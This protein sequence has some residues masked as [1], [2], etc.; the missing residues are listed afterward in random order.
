MTTFEQIDGTIFVRLSNPP[1]NGINYASRA[2]LSEALDVAEAEA[3]I[4]AVVII[5]AGKYFSCGADMREFGTENGTRVPITP[6]LILRMQAFR[7]PIVA[8]LHGAALGGGLELA[9]GAH[10][11]IAAEGTEFGLPEVNVGVV[12]GAGGTQ[13]LPRI[14]GLRTALD[15]ILSGRPISADQARSAGLVAE[16][17]APAMLE[18]RAQNLARELAQRSF[19][20]ALPDRMPPDAE[21]S[22]LMEAARTKARRS[23]TP[24]SALAAVDCLAAAMSLPLNEGLAFERATFLNLVSGTPARAVRHLFFARRKAE[25]GAEI[26]GGGAGAAIASVGVIGAGTMGTG[27]A[28]AMANAGLPV[29]LVEAGDD[30]LARGLGI[31]RASYEATVAKGRLTREE[32]EARTAR[33][34]G[35][36]DMGALVDANLVIE[37]AFEDMAV[38]LD[39]FRRLD[40]VAKPEAILATNTSRLDINAIAAATSR[41]TRV[42]GMHFFSPAHIMKLLEVVRGAATDP[43]VLSAV[44]AFARRIGKQAVLVGVCDGFVGNRMVSP[45]T[46]EAHFLVEEGASPAQVDGAL[47]RFGMAMGPLRMQDMAGLDISWAARKRLAPTRPKDIRYCRIADVICE[48][49]RFGQKTGAGFYRYEPGSRAPLPDPRVEEIANACAAESGIARRAISDEEIV[50]RTILALVNEAANIL[51]DGIAQ[52]GSDIDVIYVDGYGFPAERGGPLFYAD[53]LGLGH[54]AE[55]IKA[56]HAIHGALWTPAPLLLDLARTGGSLS[57]YEGGAGTPA[58]KAG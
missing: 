24:T 1:V 10:A 39:I 18:S 55:R 34:A 57:S 6:D 40:A 2:V 22:A 52:R 46:R 31:I 30:A 25:K 41:P 47:E 33:I 28:M 20:A 48:A 26:S 43:Q 9:L 21:A 11:R 27:I 14:V 36:T 5:G 45:Y 7:K 13:R 44:M 37:A 49:G 53:T 58:R 35:T 23:A 56:L 54:V 15:M 3:G 19:S 17:V 12:P 8:A 51:A 4:G 38:K 32:A 16:V 29:T 50:E 42:L